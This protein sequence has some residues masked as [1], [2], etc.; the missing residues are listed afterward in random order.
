MCLHNNAERLW[1]LEWR[2]FS[3]FFEGFSASVFIIVVYFFLN[4]RIGT[5]FYAKYEI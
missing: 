3:A 4:E 1:R 5:R 2:F